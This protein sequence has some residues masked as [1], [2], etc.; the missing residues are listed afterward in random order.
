MLK[1]VY[2]ETIWENRQFFFESIKWK[3]GLGW[4]R[5]SWDYH[6]TSLSL[7]QRINSLLNNSLLILEEEVVKILSLKS[8]FS[9]NVV[10]STSKSSVTNQ[11]K[12][13]WTNKKESYMIST[14]WMY[15]HFDFQISEEKEKTVPFCTCYFSERA[16]PKMSQGFGNNWTGCH[17]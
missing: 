7:R 15:F 8:H 13:N 11:G 16:K 10:N 5:F 17:L 2:H 4:R 1:K 9:S 14:R 12:F 6:F 3:L